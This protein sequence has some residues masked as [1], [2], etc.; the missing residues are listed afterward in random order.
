MSENKPIF[1]GE[2]LKEKRLKIKRN[3]AYMADLL[4]I[5]PQS[6]GEM[7]RGSI[8]PSSPNLAK[9]CII[10]KCSADEFFDV[11]ESFLQKI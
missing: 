9:L 7:E 8:S 6:Y 5:T 3:K 4:D 2:K 1:N 10:F 11:P